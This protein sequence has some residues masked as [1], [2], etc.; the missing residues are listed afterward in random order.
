MRHKLNILRGR[1]W[2]LLCLLFAWLLPQNAV[3]DDGYETFVDQSYLYNVFVSGTN[4][5][6]PM[7]GLKTL[8]SMPL[9][10]ASQSYIS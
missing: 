4:R 9:G 7:G 1:P 6:V 3:A 10:K 5:R 2:L 8:P